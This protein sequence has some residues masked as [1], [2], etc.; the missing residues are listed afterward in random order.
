MALPLDY[1]KNNQGCQYRFSFAVSFRQRPAALGFFRGMGMQEFSRLVG[2]IYECVLDPAGWNSV[3]ARFAELSGGAGASIHMVNPAS[4]STAILV[5]HGVD[6]E[7]SALGRTVYA[8][9]SPVGSAALLYDVDQPV[10]VFDIVGEAEYVESRFYKEWLEPKGYFDIMGAL[11][12]K[13]AQE[14]GAISATRLKDRGRF[15]ADSREF[16]ALIAPHVRRAVTISGTLH[17]HALKSDGQD[18]VIDTLAAAVIHVDREGRILR[19]NPAAGALLSEGQVAQAQNGRLA[20]TDQSAEKTLRTALMS[21]ASAP[22]VFGLLAARGEAY[23]I[24]V[25]PLNAQRGL[26]LVLIKTNAPETPAIGKYLAATFGLSPRE[27]AVLM[28]MLQGTGLDDIAA[29]MG[30]SVPTARSHLNKLFE[31]TATNRQA[32]L[33]AKVLGAMPPVVM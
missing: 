6:P 17:Y 18:A 30:I 29:A 25:L 24:S 7:W 32:E 3:V 2:D 4:G 15:D 9:M 1:L 19:T 21:D 22:V 26:F 23:S 28:P 20:M 14:I 11:I 10:S 31:K 8:P 13:T 5:E 16:M 33:V 12:S 27:I